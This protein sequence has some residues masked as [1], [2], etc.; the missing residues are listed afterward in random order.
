MLD[1]AAWAAF[2]SRFDELKHELRIFMNG[3][4]GF[5]KEHPTLRLRDA[6]KIHS[7]KS[8]LKD[9]AHLRAKIERKIGEGREITPD[10][11]PFSVTDLA[12]VRVL[13]LFQEDFGAIDDLIRAK[14]QIGDW[15]LDERARAY[16]W[17][18]ESVSFFENF[19]SDVE[20]R[21]TSYTSV[22]YL[23]RPRSDS[24]VCCELQVRTLFE[25]IW[26]EVDHRINYPSPTQSIA[27]REQLRV[28]SKIV[29]AGSRLVDSIR[30]TLDNA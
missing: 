21:I 30:R 14:L 22:H 3:V 28:L 10:S 20:T 27:C 18:P 15:T 7:T 6:E 11:L 25:E 12:G 29:G 23:L 19:D 24:P 9:G 5:F 1:D 26:G 8:R 16:T 13:L 2:G 17:D 4:E